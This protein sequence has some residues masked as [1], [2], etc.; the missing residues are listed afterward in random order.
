MAVS[1]GIGGD[2]TYDITQDLQGL[3]SISLGDVLGNPAAAIPQ[4]QSN[5]MN[6]WQSILIGSIFTATS[7]KIAKRVLR[8]PLS[9]INTGLFGKRGAIGPIGFK[10]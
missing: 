2:F 1:I 4:L 7:F 5:L 10:L 8:R 9:K 3:E 6:N